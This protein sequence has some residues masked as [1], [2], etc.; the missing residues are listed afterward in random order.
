MERELLKAVLANHPALRELEVDSTLF[1]QDLYRQVFQQVEADW[2]V[3]P[4][5]Q[6]TPIAWRGEGSS[7]ESEEGGSPDEVDRELLAISVDDL[8]PGDPRPLVIRCRRAALRREMDSIGAQMRSLA[9]DD[10][11]RPRLLAQVVELERR[12]QELTGDLR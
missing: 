4:I 12:R 11:Q 10:P 7:D 9:A 3:T 8:E 6:P 5:G 2:R 1:G